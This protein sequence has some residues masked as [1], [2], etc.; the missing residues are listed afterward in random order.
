[1]TFNRLCI[2]SRLTWYVAEHGVCCSVCRRLGGVFTSPSVP[3]PPPGAD[4]KCLPYLPSASHTTLITPDNSFR[5][6]QVK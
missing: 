2:Y 3:P 1:M 5:S 6:G 4:S